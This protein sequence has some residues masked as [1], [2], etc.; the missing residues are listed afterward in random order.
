MVGAVVLTQSSI[1]RE[2]IA[3]AEYVVGKMEGIVALSIDGKRNALEARQFISEAIRQVD[4]GEGVL[5]LTDLFGA[6]PSNMAFS[7]LNREK[8]EV[9]TGVNLPMIITFW[10]YREDRNIMELAKLVQLSGKRNIAR[11]KT[12]LGTT[13]LLEKGTRKRANRDSR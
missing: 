6:S 3:T 8:V 7:F 2:L 13:N 5:I 4:Q 10:N 1:S 9:V 11:A 12:L